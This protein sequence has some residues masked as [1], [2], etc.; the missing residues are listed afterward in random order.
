MKIFG[1]LGVIIYIYL[2]IY[3]YILLLYYSTEIM[4][5]NDISSFRNIVNA[6]TFQIFW[7][8]LYKLY[9][10]RKSVLGF[11]W[12]SAYKLWNS[13]SKWFFIGPR[14]AYNICRIFEYSWYEHSSKISIPTLIAPEIL[15][16]SGFVEEERVSP[17]P[18][19]L[20]LWRT[21]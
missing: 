2:L 15:D 17:Y 10:S 13:C 8:I 16:L 5:R 12:N 7:F 1:I 3:R 19:C 6:S 4:P 14:L 11:I 18:A 20:E 21:R 9:K